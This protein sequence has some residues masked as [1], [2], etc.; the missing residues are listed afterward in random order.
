MT[1]R[2]HLTFVL[3]RGT[4][5]GGIARTVINLANH[6]ADS[7]DVSLI[8]VYRRRD[9]PVFPIDPRI[10][11]Q[12]LVDLRPDAVQD[13]AHEKLSELVPFDT[14]LSAA[15]DRAFVDAV[16]RVPSDTI[17]ISTRPSLNLIAARHVPPGV[18]TVGQEHMNFETRRA[19]AEWFDLVC[20]SV[21]ALDVWVTLTE[22]DAAD[23][24]RHLAGVDTHVTS[25]PNAISWPIGEPS[26]LT[27]KVIVAAGRLAEEKAYGCAMSSIHEA[28]PMVLLEAMTSGLPM[29][30]FDCPRG[31]AE[32]IDHGRNGW[33]VKDGDLEAYTEALFELVDDPRRRVAMGAEAWRDAH[34][35]EMP[36]IAARWKE[37]LDTVGSS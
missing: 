16:S 23:Y 6:L 17:L 32:L 19:D 35:Y 7:Y 12:H 9:E 27:A 20:E 22:R 26:P 37:L 2:R 28:F 11:V 31:P 25:I 21:A 29:I 33:L 1:A 4:G 5:Q 30:A 15:S 36:K 18:V 10:H 13:P 14:Y 8:S 34:A 3:L 24:R